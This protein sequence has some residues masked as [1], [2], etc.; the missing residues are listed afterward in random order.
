[1]SQNHRVRLFDSSLAQQLT[2]FSLYLVSI[3][4]LADVILSKAKNLPRTFKQRDFSSSRHW[5][6][7]SDLSSSNAKE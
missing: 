4:K 1:M 7:S 5:R 6:D 2:Q 3:R